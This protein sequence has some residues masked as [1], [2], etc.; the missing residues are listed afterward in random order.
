[1]RESP[2][3]FSLKKLR[4]GIAISEKGCY[5]LNVSIKMVI[6]PRLLKPCSAR[7]AGFRGERYGTILHTI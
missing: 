6:S 1:M 3:N 2:K 4:L 7:Q 5:N